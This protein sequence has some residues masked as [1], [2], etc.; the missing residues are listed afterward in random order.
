M[1][2]S[3]MGSIATVIGALAGA[4]VGALFNGTPVPLLCAMAGLMTIGAVIMRRMP[5]ERT[6]HA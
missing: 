5:Q 4:A 6:T 2:A 1:A 3:V